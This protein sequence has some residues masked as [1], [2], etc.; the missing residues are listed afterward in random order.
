MTLGAKI[1]QTTVRIAFW[2]AAI[3]LGSWIL[4]QLIRAFF[5]L[6]IILGGLL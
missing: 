4:N 5:G 6:T 3:V 2:S 1:L